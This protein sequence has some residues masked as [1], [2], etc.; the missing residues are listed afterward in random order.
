MGLSLLWPQR[1]EQIFENPEG[2][3]GLRRQ[4]PKFSWTQDYILN[5]L[6]Q[7]RKESSFTFY[8]FSDVQEVFSFFDK[9]GDGC[10]I[11]RD[12]GPVLR[13]TG[14]NPTEAEITG[15]ID[16]FDTEGRHWYFTVFIMVLL[17]ECD[18]VSAHTA[19]TIFLWWWRERRI[20]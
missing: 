8:F 6:L 5:G 13:S 19:Q 15:L 20:R 3:V 10:V 4:K 12:L 7:I 11:S 18:H 17:W 1:K 14:L 9:D 16:D 2:C